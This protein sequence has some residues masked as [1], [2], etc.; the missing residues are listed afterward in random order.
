MR[1]GQQ[2]DCLAEITGL[3]F[4]AK[5][6]MKHNLSGRN[7]LFAVLLAAMGGNA[8]AGST[9]LGVARL[10]TLFAKGCAGIAYEPVSVYDSPG[11]LRIGKL[12]LDHPEYVLKPSQKC[13]FSAEVVFSSEGGSRQEGVQAFDLGQAEKGLS[14]Y[15]TQTYQKV[16]WVQG[17]TRFGRFW[18]PIEKGAQYQSLSQDLNQGLALL[19][20]TCDDS[21][22]C[23]PVPAAVQRLAERAGLE[24]ADACRGNAYDVENIVT[25]PTGRAAYRVFLAETLA[26]KYQG[27]LPV[28]A[29][30]PVSDYKG[31]W[32]GLYVSSDCANDSA[33]ED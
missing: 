21:G 32:T 16:L 27:K 4:P 8:L 23:T 29:L 19:T 15:S 2:W 26:P 24:R 18:L 12:A 22:Q 3:K 11:G 20:E 33:L 1:R 6:G 14:V 13:S 31:N 7:V 30:V 9:L 25:M 28:T 5:Q 17:N 10:P